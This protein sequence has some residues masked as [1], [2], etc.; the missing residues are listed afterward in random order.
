MK[1]INCRYIQ[2]VTEQGT[3]Q[4]YRFTNNYGLSV[5]PDE[6]D[7]EHMEVGV[8]SF[9]SQ[10]ITDY[11]LV[12]HTGIIKGVGHKELAELIKDVSEL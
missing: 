11:R 12:Y 10:S 3:H 5:V 9:Q 4:I 6:V 2:K 8:I 1:E 7:K